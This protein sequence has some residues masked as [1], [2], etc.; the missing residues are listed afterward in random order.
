METIRQLSD[1]GLIKVKGISVLRITEGH[2]RR[3]IREAISANRTR[4]SQ[5]W[6]DPGGDYHYDPRV[7]DHGEWA[8]RKLLDLG[9]SDAMLDGIRASIMRSI[10]SGDSEMQMP[11][12]EDV[13]EIHQSI[14][15]LVEDVAKSMLLGMGWG[16]VSNAYT[17]AVR[18]P[19]RSVIETWISLGQD[20]GAE[21][22]GP[23]TIYSGAGALV[24]GDVYEIEDFANR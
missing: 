9:E 4:H 19:R 18:R 2:L 7:P 15:W 20:A 14:P 23:Y 3:I 13:R 6:I 22:K 21:E 10:R 16:A 8:F 12:T 24:S 11:D 1:M 17:L 5:G